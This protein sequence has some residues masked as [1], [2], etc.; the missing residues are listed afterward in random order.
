MTTQNSEKRPITLEDLY[1]V[2]SVEDP[3]FSPDGQWIAFVRVDMDKA[4][5]GYKR[6]IWLVSTD[7]GKPLQ[8]TRSGKDSQPRW[9]PDGK[10]LAFLSGRGDKPQVYLL[11]VTAPGGEPRPLTTHP[12]G[13]SAYTW[14]PDGTQIAFLAAMNAEER[15]SEN[16]P[17]DQ[18]PKPKTKE[19]EDKRIDPRVL[20]TIPYRV[21]TSYLTDRFAQ[22]YVIPVGGVNDEAA[23]PRRLTDV[24]TNYT[25]PQWSSDGQYLYTSRPTQIDID[26]PSRSS[27]VYRVRI[28]DGQHE[29]LVDEI[30]LT[31]SPLP[32]PDGRWIAYYRA[33]HED[34]SLRINRLAVIARDSFDGSTG[35]DL[36]LQANINPSQFRWN[37]DRL[38]FSAQVRGAA[39]IYS[40]TLD[41]DI[42][43][44]M[45]EAMK[46][47]VFDVA[48]DGTLAF[49]AATSM[50]PP[51]L[52]LCRAG[53]VTQLTQFN[54]PLLDEII[55]QPTHHLAYKNPEGHDLDGW[56]VL[57]VGYET[58]KT[59]PLILDIHGGP[60]IM[61]GPNEDSMW[62]TWQYLAAQGYVTFFCNPRGSGGYGEA[63]Q[64]AIHRGW[65]DYAFADINAGVDALL[66]KGFVDSVRMAVT[67]GSY[68]GYMTV[69]IISHTDR[70]V[71]AVSQRGV[72]NLLSFFGT[73]DIPTFVLNEFGVLP[74]DDPEYLWQQSP[75]A[76]AHKIKTPLLITHSENDFRVPISEAEQ[77]FGY[78]R[79]K[80]VKTEFVRFPREGHELT[81]SGEPEHRI[82]TIRRLVAWFDASCKPEMQPG[83]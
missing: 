75:L 62:F 71:T 65:G 38:I 41:G 1:K 45:T 42:Q 14:S 77:L 51:E 12:N 23:K 52:Y 47:E 26:E 24:D 2:K 57:P 19:E 17:D 68:G 22:L 40:V 59:Y 30:H 20:T 34:L 66:E 6:N 8:L 76:H 44:L 21:G 48:P 35:R 69:W 81:R 36:T 80:G 46:A 32:S 79:R 53:Q 18:K 10:T 43:P 54:Q 29:Q 82:D 13:V 4:A 9:S 83:S 78:L 63:F 28:S 27:A 3:R 16:L 74:T 67:G 25:E 33:P 60:H 58:G 73:T 11:P 61:W 5:N 72:Y 37:G 55:V 70:F 31:G 64:Q 15:A 39:S 49:A 56:Y 7:G 50:S